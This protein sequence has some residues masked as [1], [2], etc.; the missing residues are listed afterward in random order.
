MFYKNVE[1]EDSF[2][3]M[4][5]KYFIITIDVEGDNVWKYTPEKEKLLLPE[6]KNAEYIERFQ[7]LCNKYGFKPTYLVDYEMAKSKVFVD[8]GREVLKHHEAEIGMHM[9]AFSTPP[10]Y[11]LKNMSG[12][13]LAFAGEYP[14]RVLYNK[15]EYMTKLLEDTFQIPITSHRGGRWYLDNRVLAIL[16]RLGYWV[17]CSVTPGI[18]WSGTKGQTKE[19]RG[20]NYKKY[21]NKPYRI[22]NSSMWELP[23]TI[24]DKIE[25][26]DES[27]FK[28]SKIWMRPK[29]NNLED[30]LWIVKKRRMC[31]YIEFMLHSSEFMQGENPTFRTERDIDNLFV[32][33]EKVFSELKCCGYV[34]ITCSE[35]IKKRKG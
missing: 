12:R 23:V 32:H 1:R 35:Y 14:Q 3:E 2:G 16:E 26:S 7:I 11:D 5:K 13:G 17:D 10:F 8:F 18:D 27:L 6:T 22:R 31:D 28:K 21:I 33:I 25:L 29:G 34:G 20:S 24:E 30:M 4:M 19:G 9:H 15:M